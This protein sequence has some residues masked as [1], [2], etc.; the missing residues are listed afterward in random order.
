M[1]SKSIVFIGLLALAGQFA[2]TAPVEKKEKE[3][4][5]IIWL[6]AEDMSLDLE[7]YGMPAV[8]TPNL[9]RMAEQGVRFD[10]CFVTNSIV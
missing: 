9:N 3:K 10:N 6:M 4:P 1:K 8:K 7:C 2:C 5:N